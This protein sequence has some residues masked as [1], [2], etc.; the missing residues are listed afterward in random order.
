MLAWVIKNIVNLIFL[1][2]QYPVHSI[3]VPVVLK[4]LKFLKEIS[5]L[6]A[7]AIQNF[8]KLSAK[9]ISK[10]GSR[11]LRYSAGKMQK[12][13]EEEGAPSNSRT[14]QGESV[15][16]KGLHSIHSSQGSS[17]QGSSQMPSQ[18]SQSQDVQPQGS[19]MQDSQSQD[20]QSDGPQ[21]QNSQPQGSQGSQSQGSQL[22]DSQ[23]QG[24]QLQDS[25]SQGS[26]LQDSQSQEM[27]E[28]MLKTEEQ[29]SNGH[30]DDKRSNEREDTKE[31]MKE[32]TKRDQKSEIKGELNG[33]TK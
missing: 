22:Q 13:R 18:G 24:S 3:Q 9:S 14:R 29:F 4:R 25:Q 23:S 19:Q 32:A 27:K 33:G 1:F 28:P 5:D 17:S 10:A 2:C 11:H 26:Q 20:N 30:I 6:N 21:S 7:P 16:R 8:G 12:K 15:A 31:Q